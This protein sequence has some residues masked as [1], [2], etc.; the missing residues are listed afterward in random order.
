MTELLRLNQLIRD[1]VCVFGV[2]GLSFGCVAL[3]AMLFR[4]KS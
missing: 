3:V 4:R 1:V 2:A